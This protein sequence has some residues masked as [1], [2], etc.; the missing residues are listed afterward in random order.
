MGIIKLDNYVLVLRGNN[1]LSFLNGI[2]TNL[3]ESSCSTVLTDKNAK[4]IDM[5]EVIDKDEFI[6]VVGYNEFKAS[7]LEHLTTR[8]L[9]ED[10][11]I[12][13]VSDSNTVYYSTEQIDLADGVTEHVSY[14]GRLYIV[15]NNFE[16]KDSMTSK[17]F[18]EYR[19]E[20]IIPLHGREI[21]Q[22]LHPLACGLGN[23]VHE[24]KGCYVGQE[25]LAR[26]RSRGKQG[27]ELVKLSNPVDDATTIGSEYSL[28]IRRIS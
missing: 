7:V 26:M 21:V 22:N 18:D 10:I 24:A 23:L 3:L 8:I 13:D 11:A 25:I 6:A 15:P 5:I 1:V 20:N 4:I 28:A 17:E 16:I 9:N 2:S 27:K 14:I 12:F 19:V